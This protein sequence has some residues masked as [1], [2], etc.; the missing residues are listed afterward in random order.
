MAKKWPPGFQVIAIVPAWNEAENIERVVK[1][2]HECKKQGLLAELVV[3]NDG[4][5]DGTG[6]LA[7][8]A[9]ADK[10]INLKKNRGK[11][12]A[13]AKG[14]E[15]ISNKYALRQNFKNAKQWIKKMDKVI[16]VSIDADIKNIR[17]AQVARL[18]RP[19]LKLPVFGKTRREWLNMVIGT[20]V[21]G[22][23]PVR[24]EPFNGER[25][26]R[27]RSL[28]AL[29][30]AK[31]KWDALLSAGYGLET[32]LNL[33]IP[34]T[35]FANTKFHL[36]REAEAKHPAGYIGTDMR[37]AEEYL[38]ARK[39]IKDRLREIRENIQEK[40]SR[41]GWLEHM[42]GQERQMRELTKL[43]MQKQRKR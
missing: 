32:A 42:R 14:V 27:L 9:G 29:R 35:A 23:G 20:R 15:Y 33:F 18:V 3:V 26:I 6:T 4:S 12:A 8:K 21:R 5:T 7:E 37:A 24:Y 25:A 43:K 13:Y 11:A 36:G 41:R 30:R 10:V 1:E 31:K 16:V 40:K 34:K 19:L 28:Q 22:A 38:E 39:N 17:P 2:L